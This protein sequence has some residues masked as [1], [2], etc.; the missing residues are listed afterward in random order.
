MRSSYLIAALILLGL[1]GLVGGIVLGFLDVPGNTRVA[2]AGVVLLTLGLIAYAA[3]GR[4]GR[5]SEAA[6]TDL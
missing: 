3:Y 6:R 4:T 5:R 1:L 2:Q